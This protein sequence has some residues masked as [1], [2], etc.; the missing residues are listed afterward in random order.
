MI[1]KNLD[2]DSDSDLKDK[3]SDDEKNEIEEL[4]SFSFPNDKKKYIVEQQK[5]YFDFY[6]KKKEEKEI[7]NKNKNKNKKEFED[8]N[9]LIKCYICF[10]TSKDPV[11]CRF[12]G[13]VACKNCFYKWINI[14]HNCGIC[15]KYITKNDLISPPIIGKINE[16]LKDIQNKYKIEQCLKHKEKY[17][18]FCVNC[19]KKYC[20]K[21][22]YFNSK[23]SKNHLEHKILDYTEIKNSKYNDLINQ[24]IVADE[25]KVNDNSKIYDNY[26]LENKIKFENINFALNEIKSIIYNKY[27][28]KNNLISENRKESSNTKDEISHICKN[29]SVNLKKFENIGKSIENF[30]PQQNF[31][32]LS[33]KLKKV[34]DLENKVDEI[35]KIYNNI[36]FKTLNFE[37]KKNKKE[38]W[39]SEKESI[40]INAPIYMEIQLEDDTY[41]SIVIYK[42]DLQKNEI[43][44]CPMLKFKSELYQFIRK[45]IK[46]INN[47]MEQEKDENENKIS[48]DLYDDYIKYKVFINLDKLD[49]GDN[50]FN[51]MIH[52]ISIT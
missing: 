22:L 17:L 3:F 13:N 42:E 12:C 1:N 47:S 24:L 31:E 30:N 41:F 2:S 44:L 33:Y 16:Y 6:K 7:E 36:D 51:F 45:K 29:I 43:Y 11:I 39:E 18:Y 48:N 23:E 9:V 34:K 21:C 27:N 26:I 52:K 46:D 38:I 28:E 40:I 37:I 14:H 50:T 8:F 25:I 49:D 20:G 32:K 4:E 5:K 15:R 10:N 19:S 35:H